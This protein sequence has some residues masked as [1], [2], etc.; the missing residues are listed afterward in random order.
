MASTEYDK[1][2]IKKRDSTRPATDKQT[3]KYTTNKQTNKY[4][5]FEKG[6]LTIGEK[7]KP[8]CRK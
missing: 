4:S 6:C 1:V 3:N 5:C 8:Q 2:S 7:R